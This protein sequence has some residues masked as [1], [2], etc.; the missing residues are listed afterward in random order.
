[1]DISQRLKTK[2]SD[3]WEDGYR[4]PFVQELGEAALPIEKFRFYL[5]Q[6]YQYLSAYAKLFALAAVKS[7][8]FELAARFIGLA[9]STFNEE[10][11]VH[12]D[13]MASFGISEEQVDACKAS[14]SNQ[15][16]T[17]YMLSIA[18]TGSLADIIAAV[19]PCAW[20]YA[21]YAKRLKIDYK[22]QL[23][24]NYYK[25]WIEAYASSE[26]SASFDWLFPVLDN[27]CINLDSKGEQRLEE[28]FISSLKFEYLFWE[29]AYNCQTSY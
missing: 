4:H 13:Y 20:T 16:Y 27:L 19:L 23:D 15:A 9:H 3:A 17:S 26:Y 22:A 6:D 28:I 7:D 25:S 1:M 8:T 10:I 12:R 11:K 2:A 21:D 18:F 29:T 14:L 24:N 5:L